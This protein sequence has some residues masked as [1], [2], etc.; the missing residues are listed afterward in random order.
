VPFVTLRD[1]IDRKFGGSQ[2]AFAEA[3]KIDKG[4]LC[5]YLKAERGE[6][7]GRPNADN[8]ARIQAVAGDR[9]GAVYWT[10]IDPEAASHRTRPHV[11]GSRARA[12]TG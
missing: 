3:A 2:A 8:I 12:A 6:G 7:G 4:Q 1:F 9:F 5:K 11:R 10:T